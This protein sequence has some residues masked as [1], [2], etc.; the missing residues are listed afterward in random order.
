MSVF[1]TRLVPLGLRV[2][3]LLAAAG[4]LGALAN[5]LL[6]MRIAW[7]EDWS[8]YV[9]ARAFS[10]QLTLAP[11]EQVRELAASGSHIIFD[12]RS[13]ADYEE[14]HLPGAMPLPF[15]DVDEQ[16]FQYQAILFPEQPIL[17]YCSGVECDDAIELAIY[18]RKQGFTNLVLYVG[19]WDEWQKSEE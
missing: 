12:A 10:E 19:G 9:E 11:L 7:V 14:G 15:E 8:R 13:L 16:F 5:T 4:V 3:I 6:P 2:A 17:T 18:L 1:T